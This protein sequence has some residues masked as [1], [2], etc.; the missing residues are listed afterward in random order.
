MFI[1]PAFAQDAM[2]ASGSISSTLI[3]LGAIFAI[4][5]FLLIRPQQ[6]KM[7]AHDM[8]LLSIKKNDNIV[9]GGG[10]YGKVVDVVDGDLK[11]EIAPSV[12]V[13]MPR[14]TVRDVITEEVKIEKAAKKVANA[15]AKEKKAKK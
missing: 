12:I 14:A 3:Q 9:T 2:A 5:Y 15:N 4:F 1:N 8:M 6:K 11:V 13:S 10:L 7:K